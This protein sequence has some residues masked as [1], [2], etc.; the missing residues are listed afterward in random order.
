MLKQHSYRRLDKARL[1]DWNFPPKRWIFSPNEGMIARMVDDHLDGEGIVNIHEEGICIVVA[2]TSYVCL[3][4]SINIS[5]EVSI[6][7]DG[8][9]G[10]R[11]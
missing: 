8:G 6:L 9:G 2:E 4:N 5:C 11:G 10:D 3:C 7:A 1:V